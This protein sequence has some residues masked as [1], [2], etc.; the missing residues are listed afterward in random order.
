MLESMTLDMEAYRARELGGYLLWFVGHIELRDFFL[1]FRIVWIY[2]AVY[3]P[4]EGSFSCAIFTQHDNYFTV[5]EFA[6]LYL[7]LE[8]PL[9]RYY[10]ALAVDSTSGV[11]KIG[12]MSSSQ[13]I[14]RLL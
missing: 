7:E 13:L 12:S 11:S 14:F 10:P 8:V 1:V 4:D 9:H 6:F 3:H 5:G 2:A